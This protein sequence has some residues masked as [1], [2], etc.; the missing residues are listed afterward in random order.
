MILVVSA[1]AVHHLSLPQKTD[2]FQVIFDQ[3]NIGGYFLNID[4]TLPSD[5]I[6]T[7]W[8]YTLWREWVGAR[9]KALQLE[10]SFTNVPDKARKNPDNQLNPLNTQLEALKSIGFKEVDCHY[11]N[12]LFT[13][14]S[15]RKKQ[16]PVK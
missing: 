1:F 5:Q 8:Y 11:K 16:S 13:I 10:N 4:T 6:F 12:G 2:L 7:D 3:L 15:G 9:E 14:Y